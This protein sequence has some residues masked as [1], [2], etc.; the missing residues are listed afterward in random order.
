MKTL[1]D[2]FDQFVILSNEAK[3]MINY[4]VDSFYAPKGTILVKQGEL[5]P[6]SY[7]I[8]SGIARGFRRVH[9]EEVTVSLW[10]ETQTLSDVTTYIANKPAVKSYELIEDSK[11]Y[12]INNSRF[13]AL[14]DFDHEICNLGR[15]LAEDY[16]MR[17]EATKRIYQNLDAQQKYQTF[18]CEKP[19]FIYRVKSKH[20]ASYLGI[21]PETFC[22]IHSEALKGKIE[23]MPHVIEWPD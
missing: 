2:Y 4:T 11:L 21:T 7:I 18:L 17:M 12:R 23:K 8:A 10:A 22:R 19:G 3:D 16:I 15:L 13:R 9:A 5:N 20:I 6:Y 1:S 14:F